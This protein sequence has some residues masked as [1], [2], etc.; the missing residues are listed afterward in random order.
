MASCLLLGREKERQ[1]L[2]IARSTMI[3]SRRAA[4]KRESKQQMWRNRRRSLARC[5]RSSIL[6]Q[7]ELFELRRGK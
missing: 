7:R 4:G 3:W 1:Q 2:A 5:W 6:P